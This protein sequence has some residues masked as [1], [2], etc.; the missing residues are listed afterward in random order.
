MGQMPQSVKAWLVKSWCSAAEGWGTTLPAAACMCNCSQFAHD[1][2]D[3]Q[4]PSKSSRCKDKRCP[5]GPLCIDI[6]LCQIDIG[7][8][9]VIAEYYK[10]LFNFV[11]REFPVAC[12]VDP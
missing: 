5:A 2:R 3:L 10:F 6:L 7:V 12:R 8:I 11:S 9:G 4:L 1:R